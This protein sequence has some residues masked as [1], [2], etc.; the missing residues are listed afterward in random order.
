MTRLDFKAVKGGYEYGLDRGVLYPPNASGV[1]WV[2]LSSVD[3]KSR[4]SA[5]PVYLD[6]E[7]VNRKTMVNEESFTVKTYTPPKEFQECVGYKPLVPGVRV[8]QQ[9]KLRFGFAYRTIDTNGFNLNVVFSASTVPSE[10]TFTTVS[11]I[12]TPTDHVYDCILYSFIIDGV[13][14]STLTVNNIA[15]PDLYESIETILYGSDTSD[16]ALPTKEQLIDL[17][18]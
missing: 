4:Y 14:L 9:A 11:N 7:I 3:R 16:P 15:T 8:G 1:P 5:E 6:G 18:F 2:G 12:P 10:K 17:L 13:N